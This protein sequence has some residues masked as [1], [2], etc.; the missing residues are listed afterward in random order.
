ME[1]NWC[2]F[3]AGREEAELGEMRVKGCA[4]AGATDVW[5]FLIG[6]DLLCGRGFFFPRFLAVNWHFAWLV[7]WYRDFPRTS[8][9]D[10]CISRLCE[11]QM[12]LESKIPLSSGGLRE[13]LRIAHSQLCW[14]G[15]ARVAA[16]FSCSLL[17]KREKKR[18]LRVLPTRLI[19]EWLHQICCSSTH[20]VDRRSV[21]M[22]K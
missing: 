2:A 13:L 6:H 4:A 20:C 21:H 22:Y 11:L 15:I 18:N 14:E 12:S 1:R 19:Q 8:F 10:T 3:K 5:R 16:A 17:E 7:C 9:L